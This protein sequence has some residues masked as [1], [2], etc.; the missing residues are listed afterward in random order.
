MHTAEVG[1]EEIFVLLF[2]RGFELALWTE[3]VF[4]IE[5]DRDARILAWVVCSAHVHIEQRGGFVL[6]SKETCIL[7]FGVE[8][9]KRLRQ[10]V[11][12]RVVNVF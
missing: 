11:E 4:L 1:N 2:F 10:I 6:K 3:S 9:R 12:I 5:T 8:G 7:E